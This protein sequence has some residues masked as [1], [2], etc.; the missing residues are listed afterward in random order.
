[1][2]DKHRKPTSQSSIAEGFLM[3]D[4]ALMGGRLDVGTHYMH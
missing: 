3:G 2:I 1:M 4:D